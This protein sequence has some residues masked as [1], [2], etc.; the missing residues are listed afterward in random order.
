MGTRV[1]S[2][3]SRAYRGP[4][5][6]ENAQKIARVDAREDSVRVCSLS[7]G[8][9]RIVSTQQSSPAT[10][11]VADRTAAASGPCAPAAPARAGPVL[12]YVPVAVPPPSQLLRWM[13]RFLRPVKPLVF[14]A[15]LWLALWVTTEVLA[16]RQAGNIVSFIQTLAPS[17]VAREQGLG[18]WFTSDEPGAGTLRTMLIV[19]AG[20]VA[21]YAVLRY[22]REVANT[23]MSMNM[24]FY[25]REA[26]Y[27]K[28][29]RVGFGYHDALTSG[30]LINRALSDLQNVRQFV[31]SA[32]LTSLEIGLVRS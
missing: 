29:Q 3:R 10:K 23:K 14:L 20:L 12:P 7:D 1:S 22:L 13:F 31:Q 27:D 21:A 17:P 4:R 9:V 15:C 32:V 26:V 24:V 25:I 2:A 8:T 19:L 6:F 11:Q 16:I 28:L 5:R 30:Q 18:V